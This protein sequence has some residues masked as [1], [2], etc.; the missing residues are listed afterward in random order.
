MAR[1]GE[2]LANALKTIEMRVE[3]AGRASQ[4][5]IPMLQIVLMEAP[6]C[7]VATVQ[8]GWCRSIGG[9]IVAISDRRASS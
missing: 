1:P 5:P 9:K 7:R 3:Q 4:Q 8:G 2:A 6:D